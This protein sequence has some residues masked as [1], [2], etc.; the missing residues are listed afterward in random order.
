MSVLNSLQIQE[1]LNRHQAFRKSDDFDLMDLQLADYIASKD[2][3]LVE[4]NDL[5]NR[6]TSSWQTGALI[7]AMYI[8][9]QQLYEASAKP[10]EKFYIDSS[11]LQ[12]M[13]E[14]DNLKSLQLSGRIQLPKVDTRPIGV[15][16]ESKTESI[17]NDEKIF[18]G[19]AKIWKEETKA[20]SSVSRIVMHPSYLRIIGMGKEII[21]YILKDLQKS[22]SPS[23]WFSALNALVE[24]PLVKPEIKP[25]YAGNMIKIADVWI[26]WGFNNGL[27]K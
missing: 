26:E 11:C 15:A 12:W 16:E 2:I 21:P 23:Y 9:Q 17:D 8:A 25:E 1:N 18:N 7:A 14:A 20:Q 10:A 5:L 13:L 27:L 24:E 3:K 19:L 4:K 22:P 6:R